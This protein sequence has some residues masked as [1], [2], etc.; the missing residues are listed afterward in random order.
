MR[1]YHLIDVHIALTPD[2]RSADYSW[3][4]A[5]IASETINRTTRSSV[6]LDI[7]RIVF[8]PH[9]PPHT[10]MRTNRKNLTMFFFYRIEVKTTT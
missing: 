10:W 2:Q 1:K 3:L 4:S 8:G 7:T 6:C 5:G 9:R